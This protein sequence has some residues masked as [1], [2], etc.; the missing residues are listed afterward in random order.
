MLPLVLAGDRHVSNGCLDIKIEIH[1]YREGAVEIV[2]KR[3]CG[4]EMVIV[5]IVVVRTDM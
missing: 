3:E 1:A 2:V 5:V 4:L